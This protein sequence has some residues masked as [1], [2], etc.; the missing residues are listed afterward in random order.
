MALAL[1][2]MTLLPASAQTVPANDARP[3]AYVLSKD[4]SKIGFSISH[5]VVS[6]TEGNSA[7][8]TA[9][10]N[11]TPGAPE[12]GTV[13]IHVASASVDTGIGARDDH[14]R[15]ADFFDA[16]KFPLITFESTNLV[17]SGNS[18]QLSG[19]LSLHGV[20]KP[21]TLNATLRTPD[22]N[23]DRLDF[24]VSTKLKRSDYGMTNYLG[25]IGDDVTLTIAA[26]FDRELMNPD[27]DHPAC[28]FRN[29]CGSMLRYS[30]PF[31]F[32]AGIPLLYYFAGPLWPLADIALL[33]A[34]LLTAER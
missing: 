28:P 8:S 26:E 23:A 9:R 21:I 22:L 31:L 29:R 25:V 1:I 4:H 18:G 13:V 30:S 32:L 24:S 5:F 34:L 33:L 6:S 2:A 3:A 11:F 10:V 15:T 16:G 27:R 14:L 12:H 20:T 17:R 7:P 19:M